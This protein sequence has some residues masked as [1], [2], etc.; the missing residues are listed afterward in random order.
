M[1]KRPQISCYVQ[2]EQDKES[3]SSCLENIRRTLPLNANT[4][5]V[6]V[7]LLDF[8]EDNFLGNRPK[9]AHQNRQ[10]SVVNPDMENQLFICE[11]QQIEL[12]VSESAVP[13][14]K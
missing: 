8:Y 6:L 2:D 9:Q 4:R 3:I 13:C 10:I 14:M 12:L 11:K 1:A 5:D 7:C